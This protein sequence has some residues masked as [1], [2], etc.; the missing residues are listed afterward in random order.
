MSGFNAEI[1]SACRAPIGR[2]AKHLGIT[3]KDA[4]SLYE[5]GLERLRKKIAALGITADDVETLIHPDRD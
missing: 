3:P 5:S 4:K 2:V 1:D